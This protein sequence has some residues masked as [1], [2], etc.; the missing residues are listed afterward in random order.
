LCFGW[1]HEQVAFYGPLTV[2]HRTS[3]VPIMHCD[4]Q[5]TWY[6]VQVMSFNGLPY[7]DLI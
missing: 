3:G 7:A 5:N 1:V 4:F 6:H 2:C